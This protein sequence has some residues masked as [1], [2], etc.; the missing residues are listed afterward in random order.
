[1]SPVCSLRQAGGEVS[2]SVKH[3]SSHLR[4][5]VLVWVMWWCVT[6]GPDTLLHGPLHHS[7]L[8]FLG[9]ERSLR[10]VCSVSWFPCSVSKDLIRTVITSSSWKK[11]FHLQIYI[12]NSFNLGEGPPFVHVCSQISKCKYSQLFLAPSLALA[13]WI[14]CKCVLISWSHTQTDQQIIMEDLPSSSIPK[15]RNKSTNTE[16]WW[17]HSPLGSCWTCDMLLI[18]CSTIHRCTASASIQRPNCWC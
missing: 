2:D 12:L 4:L 6:G 16:H 11:S 9:V 7:C 5:L 8:V 15:A 18:R 14:A 17:L 1:M 10:N 3:R 13:F